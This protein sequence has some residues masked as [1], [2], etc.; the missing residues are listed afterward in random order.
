[1]RIRPGIDADVEALAR[2]FTAAVHGLAAEHYDAAQREAWAPAPPSIDEWTA[3][4]ARLHTLVAEVS[5][6]IA[7]FLSYEPDGHID[8][9]FTLP[10]HARTGVASAL[11]AAAETALADAGVEALF[12]E[13]SLV[14]RP[15]FAGRGFIVTEVQQVSRRGVVLTRYAMRKPLRRAASSA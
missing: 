10:K 6:E 3:R 2:L 15:F 12:T 11:Y 13:A 7:G 1:M 5:G 14:A 4:L 8:L 9:L